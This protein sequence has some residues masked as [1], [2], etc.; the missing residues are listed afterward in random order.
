MSLRAELVAAARTMREL[1]LVAGSSGN[2]SA[3]EGDSILITPA[4]L[5][6]PE[7]TEDDLVALSPAG[8]LLAGSREPSSERR[9]H[10]AVYAARPD[11]RALVHTHSVHA[12]AWSFGDEPLDTGTGELDDAAGGAVRTA[13]FAESG[14]QK[15]ADACV[16][17]LGERSAVLLRRHGV[18]ALGSSPARALDVA[19]VVERQAQLAWLLRRGG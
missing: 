2:L 9:V 5:P 10:L 3:R 1:G 8:E 12:T 6:Y 17:A 16:E 13:A 15:L 19:A 4:G 11:A 18:L 7:L 14:G